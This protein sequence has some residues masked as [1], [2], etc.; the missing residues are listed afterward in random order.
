M[1]SNTIG[2]SVGAGGSYNPRDIFK[3]YGYKKNGFH[4]Y[5]ILLWG[6]ADSQ[7]LNRVCNISFYPLRL[8]FNYDKYLSLIITSMV[9]YRCNNKKWGLL[10]IINMFYTIIYQ[11]TQF[12]FIA[13]WYFEASLI[14]NIHISFSK[15][16]LY[17]ILFL[18]F[19]MILALFAYKFNRLVINKWS[20]YEESMYATILKD[21]IILGL[22][23][24]GLKLFWV[25]VPYGCPFALLPFLV[26][27]RCNYLE[28]SLQV[29]KLKTKFHST[30][31][32]SNS[33]VFTISSTYINW[34]NRLTLDIVGN[35][36]AHTTRNYSTCRT[37]PCGDIEKNYNSNLKM[38]PGFVTG[39]ADAES[40]FFVRV[41][42]KKN[43]KIGWVVEPV[44]TV[45]LHIKDVSLLKL[46]QTYFGGIGKIYV[47]NNRNEAIFI[48]NN[49]KEL[50]IVIDHFNKYPLITQKW[51]DFILWKQ[52]LY[53]IKNK[54]HLT[55]E[56]IPFC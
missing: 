28:F 50:Y 13:F 18:V 8:L 20:T 32:N 5:N 55:Q 4:R 16:G 11:L 9:T 24:Q 43:M 31:F 53:L 26:G 10:L 21:I 54:E 49:L 36:N 42:K 3:E 37:T 17:V 30:N 2:Q 44:F 22:F 27:W 19:I 46:I 51:S 15:I 47:Y 29:V 38:N 45:R 39:F 52:I 40:C 48:V 1:N 7:W 25:L 33:G 12:V 56:G 14:D 35:L 41:G 6:A 34:L 23:I